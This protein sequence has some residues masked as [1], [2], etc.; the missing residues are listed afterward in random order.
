MKPSLRLHAMLLAYLMVN[1]SLLAGCTARWALA[2]LCL[3]NPGKVG[4]SLI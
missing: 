3:T 4:T 1:S 2:A